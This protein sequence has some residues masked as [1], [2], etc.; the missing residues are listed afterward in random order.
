MA[1]LAFFSGLKYYEI[2]LKDDLVVE[3]GG[4]AVH[5]L[6]SNPSM[7]YQHVAL[8]QQPASYLRLGVDNIAKLDLLLAKFLL[9]L[10]QP[11]LV[12]LDEQVDGVSLGQK[13]RPEGGILNIPWNGPDH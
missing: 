3:Q 5:L 6:N 4:L 11:G 1:T 9:V 10:L 7:P 2:L 13:G 8:A 12:V